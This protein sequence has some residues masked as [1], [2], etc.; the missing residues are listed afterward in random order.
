MRQAWESFGPRSRTSTLVI[1]RNE[2][3]RSKKNVDANPVPTT[4]RS[5]SSI[6]VT[7]PGRD[8]QRI[9]GRML[10]R[11]ARRQLLNQKSRDAVPSVDSCFRI[12]LNRTSDD[13]MVWNVVNRPYASARLAGVANGGQNREVFPIWA[14]RL[15]ASFHAKPAAAAPESNASLRLRPNL[16]RISIGLL[17]SAQP[18]LARDS[19]EVELLGYY[20]QIGSH[21]QGSSS[22]GTQRGSSAV[23]LPL[24]RA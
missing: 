3:K 1:G 24:A 8:V 16:R 7:R 17:G 23:T 9:P 10:T 19:S 5:N 14:R 11:F 21:R 13:S 20:D 2:R 4:I 6:L 12:R 22:I 15:P 18:N